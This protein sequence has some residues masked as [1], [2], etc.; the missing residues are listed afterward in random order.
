M[1]KSYMIIGVI[2]IILLAFIF[3]FIGN[4]NSLV[5]LSENVDNKYA[6]IEVQLERR[7]DLIP[8]LVN[9]VKGY[10]SHEEKVMDDV[11][12]ARENL[13]NAKGVEE[14]AEANDE[15]TTAIDKLMI[16]VENYPDLKAST[17][18]INECK[19]RAN[20]NRLGKIV[21]DGNT[22]SNSDNLQ[23]FSIN[24]GCYV[25]GNIIGSVVVKKLS[26]NFIAT[27]ENIDLVDK[28]IQAQVGVKF[29]DNTTEYI[30]LGNYVIERP[31][32]EQTVNMQ[33][34]TAYDNLYTNLDKSYVC[35]IDY[36]NPDETITL[37]DLYE[38]VCSLSNL[39]LAK[40]ETTFLNSNIPITANPFTNGEKNR[41][42]LQTIAKIACSWVEISVDDNQ[43]EL[44]WLSQNS[45][46]DY[47]FQKNDYSELTGG[48]IQY[49]PINNVVIK[50]SQ[51]DDENV[52]KSDAESILENGE[53]SVVI[54]EDYILYNAE[55]RNQAITAIFNRLSGLKYT[56]ASI[57]S[58]Y[59]K[60]FLKL[61]YK[62]RVYIDDGNYVDTYVLNHDFQYDGT[63]Y[64]KVSGNALTEQ[65][66]KTKQD[67]SL[68]EAL[69][70]TQI[71]VN[72][73]K[74]EIR[75]TVTKVNNLNTTI[76]N[77]YQELNEKLNGYA[78]E[79]S[80]NQVINTVEEVQ[81]ST[82]QAI[83]IIED[84]QVKG[85]EA[86]NKE[87]GQ[88]ESL[89]VALEA[90]ARG[91]KFLNVDLYKSDAT[92]WVAKNDTEIYPP[93]NAIEGLGDT[94]AKAIVAEREKQPFISIEDVQK[95]G[96]VS[97]TLIDKMTEMGILKDLPDS[98]QL[99]LF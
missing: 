13:M 15:L 62:I 18:F 43:I 31:E 16:V 73:Q 65:E 68:A 60:P 54:S 26:A 22:I 35:G 88:A 17:N 55:L 92:V 39:N 79:D 44:C 80:V 9:T 11:L 57:I 91:I 12:K 23:S 75:S 37:A 63:F 2:L 66:I 29:A 78:T 50:N 7:A 58:Y 61:G 34:I 3:F 49:G 53:H 70:N 82:E 69:S 89:K 32:D 52:S 51:I 48:K 47:I 46:P 93:F 19:N 27:P 59:G 84:I 85:Y 74:A 21:V 45:E 90:T 71:E 24:S 87:N 10:A 20:A 42:V 83:N 95:R 77:N 86:T 38:D 76:N 4:Y 67:V 96:K 81:T 25:D 14:Q 40:K 28:E 64:S 6:D 8:N 94:V 56:D 97:K 5:T 36:E 30:N 99:S 72:K 98:N 1:K 41:T 33:S